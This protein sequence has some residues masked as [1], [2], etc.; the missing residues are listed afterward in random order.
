MG[1][2]CF[3]AGKQSIDRTGSPAG[4]FLSPAVR[5]NGQNQHQDVRQRTDCRAKGHGFLLAK[6]LDDTAHKRTEDENAK[7][8]DRIH[9]AGDLRILEI[10]LEQDLTCSRG[11]IHTNKRCH[12][13]QRCAHSRAI[14]DKVVDRLHD[15]ELWCILFQSDRGFHTHLCVRD[16]KAEADQTDH[17]HDQ[18][19][20]KHLLTTQVV[21]GDAG[22]GG[23][24]LA[25]GGGHGGGKD[26]RQDQARQNGCQNAVLCN[27][28]CNADDDRLAGG[29]AQVLQR[30]CLGHAKAHH[31]D[32]D[33]GCHGNDDPHTGNA[34][35]EYQLL[36]ILN[37]HEAEQ[38]VG[39][40]EVAQAPRHGGDDVQQAVRGGRALGGVVAGHHGQVTGQALSVGYNGI[41]AACRTNA[42]HQHSHKGQAH[43][44]GL[45]EVG[46]GNGAEAARDGIYFFPPVF[47][48]ESTL[49]FYHS[50]AS[51][52][53]PFGKTL[54]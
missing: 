12:R 49:R 17:T 44:D 16:H 27:E 29:A 38:D 25:V 31:A 40:S 37:G 51:K 32:D 28:V 2:L 8:G 22:R 43:H 23:K 6:A 7:V 54:S 41:P 34:A 20:D 19:N 24:H 35:A 1:D 30:A 46:G 13:C 10:S 47:P 42:V 5:C 33:G 3:G 39:H 52:C 36:F 18:S 45:D 15:V 9:N 11:T 21:L 48:N 14:M 50:K 4:R 26:A 53:K